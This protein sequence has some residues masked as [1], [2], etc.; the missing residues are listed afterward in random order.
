METVSHGGSSLATASLDRLS[1]VAVAASCLVFLLSGLVLLP[2]PGIQ[3]DEALFAAPL[4][5]PKWNIAS[6]SIGHYRIPLMQM[7]YLGC[8]KAWLYKPIFALF[9]PSI[10][11][12]RLPVVFI[13]VLTIYLFW[14]LSRRAVGQRAAIIGAILLATDSSFLLTTCFDWGPVALQHLLEL[15]AVL[16]L[17]SFYHSG[18]EAL[19]GFGFFWLGLGLWDKALFS[20]TLGA[21]VI[22]T[23]LVYGREVWKTIN[24]RRSAI[25]LVCFLLGAFPLLWYNVVQQGNTFGNNARFT[26]HGLVVKVLA[27]EETTD[28][29]AFFGYLVAAPDPTHLRHP[30]TALQRSAVALG[31]T[32]PRQANFT[33]LAFIVSLLLLPFLWRTKARKPL[34]FALIMISV[35]WL[36]M[37]ITIGA[38]TG[39]HH[40]ILLWPWPVF[41]VSL[42]FSEFSYKFERAGVLAVIA[43]VFVLTI[44]NLLVTD[45]YLK[46]LIESGPGSAWTDAI[47]GLAD[48]LANQTTKNIYSTD[49]GMTNSLRVLDNGTLKLQEATFILIKPVR[50]EQD[51]RFLSQMISGPD[52]LLISH[53]AAF[54]AFPSINMQLDRFA[55]ERGLHR[56]ILDTIYDGEG[57][58][59]FHVFRFQSAAY[60]KP[61]RGAMKDEQ[62]D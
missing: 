45:Q 27:L 48:R 38:G 30:L 5:F 32:L 28:G 17:F 29:S 31:Q 42:A 47:S 8:L 51:K 22:S 12:I 44:T 49:W 14:S 4:F 26:L 25:A 10:Y 57:H 59:L 33:I 23:G 16:A 1:K 62:V 13:G 52:N 43:G 34:L 56:Q 36:Q 41:F 60:E 21:L 24:W 20:W 9:S 15:G 46:Q 50:S 18:S 11:S 6:I 54:Q 61:A 35:T 7:T 37:G 2:Y 53:T 19:L 58:A 55:A 3:N 39:P 40:V